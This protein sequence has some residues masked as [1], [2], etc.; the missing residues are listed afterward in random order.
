MKLFP[1]ILILISSLIYSQNSTLNTEKFKDL[2]SSKKEVTFNNDLLDTTLNLK[3]ADVLPIYKGCNNKTSN[4]ER[5]NCLKTNLIIDS[6]T[7]FMG[8]DAPKKSKLRKGIKRI[9]VVFIINE[10]GKIIVKRILGKWPQII[11]DEMTKA[12]EASPKM[13]PATVNDKNISVKYSIRIPFNVK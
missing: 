13:T 1:L 2:T 5:E 4:L 7:K 10:S 12:I 11:I 9:R 6:V 8:S 3:D